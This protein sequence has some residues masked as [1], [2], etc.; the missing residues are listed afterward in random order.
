MLTGLVFKNQGI[1]Q[2]V[3]IM[4]NLRYKLP[5]NQLKNTLYKG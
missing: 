4:C 2:S 1:V 5:E 3:I